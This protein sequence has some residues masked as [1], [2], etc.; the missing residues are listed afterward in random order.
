MGCVQAREID[1]D[2][3]YDGLDSLFVDVPIEEKATE[4]KAT[5]AT[6][7]TEATDTNPSKV[8][9]QTSLTATP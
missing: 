3:E 5:E 8:D 1:S 6:E 7:A 9:I 2:D 4:A